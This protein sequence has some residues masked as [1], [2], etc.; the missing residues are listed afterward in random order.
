[1]TDAKLA[2]GWTVT[3]GSDAIPEITDFNL[4]Q[5]VAE[6]DV[7]SHDSAGRTREFV[8]GLIDPQEISMTVNWAIADHGFLFDIQG[9]ESATDTLTLVEPDASETYT[10]D[11]WVKGIT[12]HA[13]ATGAAE[14]ADIVFRT[15]G[16]LARAGS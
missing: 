11:A 10:I 14:T 13:P 5:T 7:T 6:V 1:M 12:I 3:F 15:T 8:P 16:V 9:D 2:Q 4:G